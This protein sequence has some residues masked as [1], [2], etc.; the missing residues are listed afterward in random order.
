[1]ELYRLSV[2]HADLVFLMSS[3]VSVP[4]SAPAMALDELKK[5]QVVSGDF[6]T[7]CVNTCMKSHVHTTRKKGREEGEMECKWS[8]R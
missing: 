3:V 1:M 5:A 4:F 2:W 7:Q 8:M 6:P